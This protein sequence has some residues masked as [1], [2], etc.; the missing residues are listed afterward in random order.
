[1][2]LTMALRTS[3]DTISL[4]IP[5]PGTAVSLAM[6]VRLRLSWR[7]ISSITRSGVPTAMKPPIIRLAP[8]GINDTD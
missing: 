1:M 3:F 4:P 5:R 7:T 2:W 6:T 8:S